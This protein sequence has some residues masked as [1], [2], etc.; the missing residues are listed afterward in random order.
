MWLVILLSGGMTGRAV[1][2]EGRGFLSSYE[3]TEFVNWY[4]SYLFVLR[5][6]DDYTTIAKTIL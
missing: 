5:L 6:G 2:A 4:G 3:W 1:C